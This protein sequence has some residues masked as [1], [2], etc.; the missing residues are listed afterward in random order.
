MPRLNW[1]VFNPTKN[2]DQTGAKEETFDI[3]YS[4]ES[5][6]FPPGETKVRVR[7][8]ANAEDVAKQALAVYQNKGVSIRSK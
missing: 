2:D 8:S 6:H 4:G 7:G 5:Y 3:D 1:Y